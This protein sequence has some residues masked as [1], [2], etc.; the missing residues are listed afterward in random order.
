MRHKKRRIPH[1][2]GIRF[3][4]GTIIFFMVIILLVAAI[5]KADRALRPVASMRAEHFALLN[6]NEVIEKAVSDYLSENEWSYGDF[7]TIVY[8]GSG[9]PVSIAANPYNINKVQS[10]LTLIINRRLESAGENYHRIAIGSLTGS[11][12]FAGK[13]P[14]IRIR[15]CPMGS[16]QVELLSSFDSSGINQTRHRLTA[17]VTVNVSSSLPLYEFETQAD[18]EF[19]IAENV[20]IGSVPE[21][22]AYG[23]HLSSG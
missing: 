7:S 23:W 16:A 20:I 8:N 10:E 12:I 22:G 15:V 18:F 3:K 9:E 5:V 17:A 4:F 2:Y 14:D 21:I 19:L 13:G 1:R 11:Y 6:T